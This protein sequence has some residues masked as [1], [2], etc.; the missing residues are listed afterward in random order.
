MLAGV[1]QT[2]VSR[3]LQNRNNVREE[4]RAKVLRVLE[5][6]GYVANQQARSMR[7][8]KSGNIGVVTGRIKNPF[9]PELLSGLAQSVASTDH[10]MVLWTADSPT[11]D[12]AAIEAIQSGSIEGLIFTTA[13][14][15]SPVL[16][17]AL[18]LNLPIV[19][20]NRSIRGIQC[21]QVTSDN[22]SGGRRVARYFRKHGRSRMAVVGG[23]ENISTGKER[24]E[25][26]FAQCEEDAISLAP[27][28]QLMCDFTHEDARRVGLEILQK[29]DRPDAVFCVNDLIA[30]GV[31]DAAEVLGIRVPED[32]WI[33]GFDN[34]ESSAWDRMSLTTVAQPIS[35]MAAISLDL[36]LKRIEDPA[37]PFEHQKF[38]GDLIPRNT[39]AYSPE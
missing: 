11:G 10:R 6:T 16:D 12:A 37:R 32:L 15:D 33:V 20:T 21:D 29:A 9:Y 8:R 35:E 30:F 34:I 17:R 19:L 4:T 5:E 18:K 36:L 14:T 2:T 13:T 27:E 38:L 25:G 28:L 23:L 24:R 1:S 26:F 22:V 7:M 39:T 3:V 31:R